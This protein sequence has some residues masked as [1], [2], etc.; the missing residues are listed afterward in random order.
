MPN[1]L[2]LRL[3]TKIFADGADKESILELCRQPLIQGFTTNP[4]LMRKAGVK[5]YEAFAKDI[6]PYLGA[7]PLSLEVFADDARDIF[8]QAR[9]ISGWGEHVY[10]KVPV[11]N[12]KGKTL[13]PVIQSLSKSGIKVNITAVMTVSQV[14]Q[15]SD[16]LA[17]GP[18]SY[19]SIFAGR[20]ADTGYDPK[21]IVKHAVWHVGAYPNIELIWASPREVLNIFEANDLGCHIITVTIDILK[22]LSLVGK[23]LTEYSR[24][25]SEMFFRDGAGYTI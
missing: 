24:E 8:D 9:K 3:R 11:V 7:L 19:I 4:T 25:T 1:S 18:P 13:L 21:I 12:S 16:A 15:A 2:L 17:D 23:D 22:K 6:I 20:I 10:V 14:E 5:D